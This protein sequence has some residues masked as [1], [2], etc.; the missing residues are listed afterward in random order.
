MAGPGTVR[1]PDAKILGSSKIIA[2]ALTVVPN[3]LIGS[4]DNRIALGN[5]NCKRI[6]FQRFV[7]IA[8]SFNDGH[9]MPIN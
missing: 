9:V 7:L 8:I 3:R 6:N 4:D 2:N 1:N 5:E